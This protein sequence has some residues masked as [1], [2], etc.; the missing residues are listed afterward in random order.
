MRSLSDGDL[1]PSSISARPSLFDEFVRAGGT[2]WTVNHSSF[3][4]AS[5]RYAPAI[6]SR[7]DKIR[8]SIPLSILVKNIL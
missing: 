2:I 3:E 5:S 6:E 7:N 1:P 4:E 8:D